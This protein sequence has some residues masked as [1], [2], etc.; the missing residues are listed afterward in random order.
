MQIP[1]RG[2]LYLNAMVIMAAEPV[3]VD[4]GAAMLRSEYLRAAFSVVEPEDVRWIFLSH[5]DRDHAGNVM[6]LLVLCPNAKLVTNFQGAT[7]LNKEYELPMSRIVFVD[8]GEGFDVGD[9]T[10]VPLRPPL[11]DSPSTRGLLD[12]KSRLYYSVDAFAAVVP[13]YVPDV[14]DVPADVYEE[15]FNWLNRANAPWYAL[16]DPERL[17]VEIDRIRRLNPDVIV[18]YH[19]PVA[20]GR[21][22]QLCRMLGAMP[23]NDPIHFPSYDEL[24]KLLAE[25]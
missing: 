13:E 20:Y 4:T 3:L 23:R 21:A 25:A 1:N 19:G 14:S 7:R 11:F 12:T 2:V 18:S 8:N 17:E 9:R 5:D 24:A 15:G 16:T 6:Q 22:E 10:L